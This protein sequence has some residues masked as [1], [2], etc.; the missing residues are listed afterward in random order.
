MNRL[1]RLRVIR[2]GLELA[3]KKKNR[4]EPAHAL[5]MSV[6]KR[7]KYNT[8]NL[9]LEEAFA[10]LRG[11]SFV[12]SSAPLRQGD[13]EPAG[14]VTGWVI[15]SINGVSLGWGKLTGDMLKNHYP[16]GLRINY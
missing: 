12:P 4:L 7:Q 13:D 9:T 5:A 16:K 14:P 1:N 3:N 8:C 11:E 6:S 2:P 15:A 10:F